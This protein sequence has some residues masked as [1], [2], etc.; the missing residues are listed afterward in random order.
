MILDH[1]DENSLGFQ[2]NISIDYN[3]RLILRSS[4]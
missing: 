2:T 1:M 3:E 4:R